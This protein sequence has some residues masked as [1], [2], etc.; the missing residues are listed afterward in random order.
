MKVVCTV[1]V[2]TK[3]PVFCY[4]TDFNIFCICSDKQQLLERESCEEGNM[5]FCKACFVQFPI[6]PGQD[7]SH[8][9]K[10]LFAYYPIISQNGRKNRGGGGFQ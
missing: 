7:K 9:S 3:T 6:G 2:A 4:K 1:N 5:E 10:S 8:I